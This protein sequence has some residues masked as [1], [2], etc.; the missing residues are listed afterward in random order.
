[1]GLL[2]WTRTQC[3]DFQVPGA[4][5]LC[6]GW[7]YGWRL[8][9]S[10]SSGIIVRD[11]ASA[12]MPSPGVVEADSGDDAGSEEM[13]DVMRLRMPIATILVMTSIIRR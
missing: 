2:S 11:V 4:F 10:G 13:D 8:D 1:M 9:L 5:G 3:P 7:F 6:V 12:L